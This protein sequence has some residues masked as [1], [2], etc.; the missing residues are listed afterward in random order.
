MAGLARRVHDCSILQLKFEELVGK[1]SQM[2]ALTRRVVTRWN[3]DFD[4]LRSH[5]NLKCAVN[6]LILYDPGLKK[7]QLNEKQW[8]LACILVEQLQV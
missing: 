8:D 1:D 7:Y 5:V 2:R 4:C 6:M 3:T